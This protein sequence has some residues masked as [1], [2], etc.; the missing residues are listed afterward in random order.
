MKLQPC[1]NY[2][3]LVCVSTPVTGKESREIAIRTVMAIM[4]LWRK[5]TTLYC[6]WFEDSTSAVSWQHALSSWEQQRLLLRMLYLLTHSKSTCTHPHI[7]PVAYPQLE[8]RERR[9]DD[10]M[11]VW[12]SGNWDDLKGGIQERRTQLLWWHN[13]CLMIHK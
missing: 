4:L 9:E 2:Q 11:G 3:C 12:R 6:S 8:K 5:N 10:I 13:S 7:L 1:R